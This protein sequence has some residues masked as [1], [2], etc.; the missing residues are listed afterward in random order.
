MLT[1]LNIGERVIL[2]FWVGSTWAIGYIAAPVLF[3]FLA[4]DRQ[5]AGSIA[6]EMLRA[7]LSI[8][9]VCGAILMITTAMSGLSKAVRSWRWWIIIVMLLITIVSLF[10]IHPMIADIKSQKDI[11]DAALYKSQF[12]KLHGLS[13]GLY[14]VLSLLG[15]ALVVFGLRRPSADTL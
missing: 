8:G 14:L 10:I 6:G 12:G 4:D 3:S 11:M 13:S 2:T 5:L 15:L 9:L 1:K 7:V